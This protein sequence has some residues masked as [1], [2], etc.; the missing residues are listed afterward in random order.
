MGKNFREIA[1][2]LLTTLM[3]VVS[4]IG[5]QQMSESKANNI[6][7]ESDWVQK[8]NFSSYQALIEVLISLKS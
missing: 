3:L 5:C 4:L 1:N 2:R 7:L 8:S 6:Q